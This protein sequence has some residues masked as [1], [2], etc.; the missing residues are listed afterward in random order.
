MN[1]IESIGQSFHSFMQEQ[2]NPAPEIKRAITFSLNLDEQK[3]GFGDINSNAALVLAK[4]LKQK[5]VDVA[6]II[7]KAFSHKDIR[8]VEIAGP[9]FLNFFLT[10]DAYKKIAH[11][12]YQGKDDFFKPSTLEHKNYSLEFVSANPTGPLHFGHGR[13]G[14]IGDVLGK[15]L[16]FLGNKVTKEFYINDAGAQIQKLGRSLKIRCQQ[17]LGESVELPEEAYHGEYL[18]ELAKECIKTHGKEVVQKPDE[19][20]AAYGKEILLEKIKETL[21]LYGIHFDVWFSEKTL[22]DSGSIDREIKKLGTSGNTYEKDGALWFKSTD[23]GDDKDRVLR[24]KDG[25]LTYVAADIAYLNNKLGRGFD[26]LIMILG[27]DH[28]SYVS[29]LKGILQAMG[30]NPA[31]LDVILY[32]LV[33]LKEGGAAVRMSKRA[34]KIVNLRDIIET[35]GPDVARFFYLNR[36]ADAHLEF[37]IELALKKT[38]ENPVYYVQYAYVRTCSILEK[39]KEIPELAR[40]EEKDLDGITEAEASLIKKIISL[41]EL[42]HG[43]GHHYQTHLLTYYILELAHV[44]HKYYNDHRV[45]DTTNIS[46]SKARLLM[47]KQ[48]Q[49]TF[50]LALTLLGISRPEKM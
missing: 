30:Y 10:L 45:I 20:F 49:Q 18:V 8:A 40:L 12:L 37:D 21:A 44:F 15:V 29:R 39:A 14:I 26:H 34:G 22:H 33:T 48:L 4:E 50:A 43:I 2:F 13:G 36:K 6:N 5:P 11:E 42:L 9:G 31:M 41:K 25:E 1:L 27:Q 24:K 38:E 46:Q 32:Q 19:F 3:K 17:L 23:Y 16:S 35:V 7:K 47:I 28:H